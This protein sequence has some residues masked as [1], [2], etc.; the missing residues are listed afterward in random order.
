MDGIKPI[1]LNQ[2]R[3]IV[4]HEN[5]EFDGDIINCFIKKKNEVI[6]SFSISIE[7]LKKCFSDVYY[8]L[9]AI[10][11]SYTIFFIYNIEEMIKYNPDKLNIRVEQLISNTF[12]GIQ[13]K[14]F[15]IVDFVEDGI[16]SKLILEDILCSDEKQRMIHSSQFLFRL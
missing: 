16:E 12:L 2:L 13:S 14:G 6:D 10:K 15:K 5:Y 3:N 8:I 4:A 11:L 7:Q 9:G 1:K